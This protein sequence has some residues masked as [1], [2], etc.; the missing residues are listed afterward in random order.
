MQV[1]RRWE[2]I[3]ALRQGPSSLYTAVLGR[4][5]N[6]DSSPLHQTQT[7]PWTSALPTAADWIATG[8]TRYCTPPQCPSSPRHAAGGHSSCPPPLQQQQQQQQQQEQEQLKLP[9]S[10]SSAPWPHQQPH[11]FLPPRPA[12]TS[13]ST[14]TASTPPGAP[15]PAASIIPPPPNPISLQSIHPPPTSQSP[16]TSSSTQPSQRQSLWA[17][18]AGQAHTVNE[19]APSPHSTRLRWS[20]MNSHMGKQIPSPRYNIVGL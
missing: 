5:R 16:P 2:K 4:A 8:D 3:Q 18:L 9:R 10:S 13:P 7:P 15:P 11:P 14:H 12:A 6:S 19:T 17:C 1:R 20:H